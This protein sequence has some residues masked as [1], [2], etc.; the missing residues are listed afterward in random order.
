MLEIT[1]SYFF[2]FLSIFSPCVLPILPIIFASSAGDARKSLIVLLGLTVG[3]LTI[4]SLSSLI[5]HFLRFLAYAFLI[6]FALVLLSEKLEFFLTS[7]YRFKF[8]TVPSPF[9]KGFL[10]AFIWLPCTFPFLGFAAIQ[11]TFNIFSIFSYLLGMTSSIVV[12]TK[13]SR[14]YIVKNFNLIKKL[15]ALIIFFFIFYS[16]L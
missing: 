3:T 14:K 15:A 2:G 6:F 7:R 5:F 1:I 9:F 12:V 8:F 11:A 16:L 10:L 13:L 4:L